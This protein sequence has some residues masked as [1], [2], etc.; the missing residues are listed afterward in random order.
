MK[1]PNVTG[2][3]FP[4]HLLHVGNVICA[5]VSLVY[6]N[7]QPEYELPSQIC[8][9]Q[10]QKFGKISVGATVLPIHPK[11]NKNEHGSEFLLI[12][13][14]ASDLTFLAQLASDI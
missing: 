6:I 4:Y 14:C 8:F 11:E 12:A 7:L 3:V 2:T 1:Y 13:T 10:F 9:G 5:A